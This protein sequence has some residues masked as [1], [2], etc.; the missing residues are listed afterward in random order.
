MRAEE[1][2][3]VLR[4]LPGNIVFDMCDKREISNKIVPIHQCVANEL[5]DGFEINALDSDPQIQIGPLSLHSGTPHILKV[6]LE[7]PANTTLEVFFR[8][9]TRRN[10]TA[11]DSVAKRIRRGTNEVYFFLPGPPESLEFIRID[12]GAS[13]GRYL[14]KEIAIKEISSRHELLLPATIDFR[15]QGW[16]TCR[17]PGWSSSEDWGTWT[18]GREA[19][20][21]FPLQ[22]TLDF[23]LILSADALAFV[24]ESHPELK[25][26][27]IANGSPVGTWTFRHNAPQTKRQVVIPS[28]VLSRKKTLEILF[29]FSDPVSPASLGLSGD[30]RLLGIGVRQLMLEENPRPPD[31]ERRAEMTHAVGS[32]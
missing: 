24:T 11:E 15:S 29:R 3:D 13:P 14:V 16:P 26:D 18:D 19:R 12:P 6:S 27:I 7:S 22:Q 5:S 21:S 28:N 32:R 25:V 9:S 1:D 30:S 2:P 8:R 10:Y 4:R 17:G 31:S 20:L 23:D